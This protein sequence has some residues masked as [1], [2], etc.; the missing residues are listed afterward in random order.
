MKHLNFKNAFT[1]LTLVLIS[2]GFGSIKSNDYI[3]YVDTDIVIE[4]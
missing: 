2:F 3:K 4:L 1:L